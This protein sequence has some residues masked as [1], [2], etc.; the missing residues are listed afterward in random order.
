MPTRVF[1]PQNND[2]SRSLSRRSRS[3]SDKKLRKR[4]SSDVLNKMNPKKL[5]FYQHIDHIPLYSDLPLFHAPYTFFEMGKFQGIHD[6][7]DHEDIKDNQGLIRFKSYNHS[8][9]RIQI[10]KKS[11]YSSSY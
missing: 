1:T 5:D 11:Y 4:K 3:S 2:K 8:N 7:F 9:L 6:I 10:Q